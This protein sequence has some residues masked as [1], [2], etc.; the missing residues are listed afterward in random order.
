[1][2]TVVLIGLLLIPIALILTLLYVAAVVALPVAQ[3]VYGCYAALEAYNGRPFRY[4]WVVD[5]DY[6]SNINFTRTN[7]TNVNRATIE[8]ILSTT[9]L[10]RSWGPYSVTYRGEDR[11]W[12]DRDQVLR[13]LPEVEL[14]Q[15]STQIGRSPV[16]WGYGGSV[17]RLH[18]EQSYRVPE[19]GVIFDGDRRSAVRDPRGEGA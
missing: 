12:P 19:T 5:L 8:S 7:S 4:R 16:Y 3:V 10:T 15:R 14:L 17:S 18:A 2:L 11:Q 9:Y 1:M 6:T 13:R